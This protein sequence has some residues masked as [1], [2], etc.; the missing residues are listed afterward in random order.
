MEVKAMY[1]RE[2]LAINFDYC[3]SCSGTCQ[4]CLLTAE[5]R[6]QDRALLS[7]S[8]I[9]AVL[10]EI[11][12]DV[13]RRPRRLIL[14]IGRG[15]NL[16]LPESA[17]RDYKRIATAATDL[18]DYEEG[19]VEVSTSLVGKLEPQMDRAKA[20]LDLLGGLDRPYDAKF[21]VVGNTA[22]S[23]EKYWRNLD[24]FFRAMRDYRGGNVDG[25]GD[26]ILLNLGIAS[27][28]DLDWLSG[29]L[30]DFHSPVN[31]T[32]VPSVDPASASEE[33]LRKL[34][35]WIA[36]LHDLGV[37]RGLDL[38]IVQRLHGA[39][40]SKSF[41]TSALDKHVAMSANTALFVSPDGAWHYG[42]ASV[43]VD[44]DPVR[45]EAGFKDAAGVGHLVDDPHR[46]RVRLLRNPTCRTCQFFHV[47]VAAGTYRIALSVL[48]RHPQG[49]S[50]CPCAMKETFRRAMD[51]VC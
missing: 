14:G 49:L 5:E 6:A 39:L 9:G 33:G 13:T 27:L 44:M 43:L 38:N 36:D 40:K 8:R 21:V 42:L 50:C 12:S 51:H 28:P 34:E 1:E 20:I 25:N 24:T 15:N 37:W 18:F 29:F 26:I 4:T 22:L 17:L 2:N 31:I 19:L 32:W 16:V 47:C 11:A 7:V 48:R 41:D 23:S 10:S 46:D 35:G 30:T 45:F 3:G